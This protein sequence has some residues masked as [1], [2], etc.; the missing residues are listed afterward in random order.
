LRHFAVELEELKRALLEMGALVEASIHCSVQALVNR[1][2]DMARRV[3]EDESCINQME[4]DIDARVTRLLALNQPVAGDLRLLIIALKINTDLERIGDM[5]VSIAERAIS[6]SKTIPLKPLIDT[7]GMALLVEDMLHRSLDSFVRG[8]AALAD[9]VLPADDEVDALRDN[10]YS[11]LLQIM[12]MN[13]AVVPS[14]IHLMFVARN[15]ERIA[16][17]ATNIAE[18]VIFLVRGIDI[19]HAQPKGGF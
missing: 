12:Q 13:P 4:L 9:K 10:I 7:P 8:D 15:L 19:R 16:D 18:D 1:D 11:E 17:H 6:L 5:A 14:A 3:I 2:E